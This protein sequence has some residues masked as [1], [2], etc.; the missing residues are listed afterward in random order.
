MSS[1]AGSWLS[2]TQFRCLRSGLRV[3][4]TWAA[5]D[6][7]SDT[8]LQQ[9][10][11]DEPDPSEVIVGLATV[12]RLLAIELAAATGATETEV[13]SRLAA[14]VHRLQGAGRDPG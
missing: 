8:A 2:P 14:T 7:E 5:E 11:H 9:A 6:R 13:L 12:S 10:L 4:T 1:E 3:V